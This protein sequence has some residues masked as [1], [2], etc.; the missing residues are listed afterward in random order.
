MHAEAPLRDLTLEYHGVAGQ[1][2]AIESA[3]PKNHYEAIRNPDGCEPITLDGKLFVPPSDAPAP[4]VMIV[5]GSLGVG[6]N[7]LAH[8]ETL[9]GEGIGVLVVDPF[10]AR[11]VQ[12]TVANQVQYSF[13]ASAFDVLAA[14]RLL[15]ARDDVDSSRISAQGH[16]RGGSAVTIAAMRRFADPVVGTD[17]A[18]AG[19]YAVYPW[20]GQQFVDPRIGDTRY[21]AIVGERDEWV[22]I[23]QVQ[24]QTHAIR[25]TGA[26]A[27]ARIVAAAQHSF[28]RLEAVYTI[29][30]AAVAPTAATTYLA[31]DGAMI[32]SYTGE[33][34][35][36]LCDY[37]VFVAAAKGGHA[38]TG[39]A[40]GGADGEPELFR[41]DMLRFHHSVLSLG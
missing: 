39:A 15:R 16:S 22:S 32:D 17:A 40:I 18:F 34:K 20:C 13:A 7:H 24:S 3:N 4:V 12:S 33:A 8:A 28:D 23:Q 27:S 14:L 10:G 31:D 1:A 35:P 30:D 19:V 37:D 36:E 2:V 9:V 21:R 26:D 41:E 25:L 5:P 29:E 11:S 38:R 6:P